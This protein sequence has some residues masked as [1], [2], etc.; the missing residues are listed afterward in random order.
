M[1]DTEQEKRKP[2]FQDYS[3]CRLIGQEFEGSL[4]QAGLAIIKDIENPDR[5]LMSKLHYS[6]YDPNKIREKLIRIEEYLRHAN[7]HTF[8]AYNADKKNPPYFPVLCRTQVKPDFTLLEVARE[9]TK[10]NSK[11]YDKQVTKSLAAKLTDSHSLNM[12]VMSLGLLVKDPNFK[13]FLLRKLADKKQKGALTGEVDYTIKRTKIESCVDD[14]LYMGGFESYTPDAMVMRATLLDD[15]EGKFLSDEYWSE[16]PSE[17]E[18]AV[19]HFSG[20]V[21]GVQTNLAYAMQYSLEQKEHDYTNNALP[22]IVILMQQLWNVGA[23]DQAMWQEIR[24]TFP[25]EVTFNLPENLKD[26]LSEVKQTAVEESY[27]EEAVHMGD[28]ESLGPKEV[29]F[30]KKYCSDPTLRPLCLSQRMWGYVAKHGAKEKLM[31]PQVTTAA[32]LR[33]TEQKD[34]RQQ[35]ARVLQSMLDNDERL[36]ELVK[37]MNLGE[38]ST[39]V[40]QIMLRLD[41]A[42]QVEHVLHIILA[43]FV[44]IHH[45]RLFLNFARKYLPIGDAKQRLETLS[46]LFDIDSNTNNE[47]V[48]LE[49]RKSLG[50]SEIVACAKELHKEKSDGKSDLGGILDRTVAI[51]QDYYIRHMKQRIAELEQALRE[52]R[53]IFETL[54]EKSKVLNSQVAALRELH[55]RMGIDLSELQVTE[56]D[57][58]EEIRSLENVLIGRSDQDDPDA[59]KSTYMEQLEAAWVNTQG[60]VEV[61]KKFAQQADEANAIMQQTL[62]ILTEQLAAYSQEAD[63][64]RARIT[65][66]LQAE[67]AAHGQQELESINEKE[68]SELMAK[69]Q[70]LEALVARIQAYLAQSPQGSECLE[71]AAKLEAAR[72]DI[73]ELNEQLAQD[74]SA[75][76]ES[77]NKR[78]KELEEQTEKLTT[79]ND[80]ARELAR[81][82]G[83]TTTEITDLVDAGVY[84]CEKVRDLTFTAEELAKARALQHVLDHL[85]RQKGA[86]AKQKKADIEALLNQLFTTYNEE[87]RDP[88]WKE[89]LAILPNQEGGLLARIVSFFIG[90]KSKRIYY[91][92]LNLPK[93]DAPQ[94]GDRQSETLQLFDSLSPDEYQAKKKQICDQKDRLSNAVQS[95]TEKHELLKTGIDQL[96][97]LVA[98]TKGQLAVISPNAEVDEAAQALVKDVSE[99]ADEIN[100]KLAN[101]KLQI[102]ASK[103]K[104]RS[105]H[106]ELS[107]V[108][109]FDF[110]SKQENLKQKHSQLMQ[111]R[112]EL[113]DEYI[114]YQ[115]ELKKLAQDYGQQLEDM[116][117]DIS[118]TGRDKK[119]GE[120]LKRLGGSMQEKAGYLSAYD[121][122]ITHKITDTVYHL[123]A[124]LTTFNARYKEHF[125]L[126]RGPEGVERTL[127]A[128][129][130]HE[131]DDAAKLSAVQE[132][133]ADKNQ[134]QMHNRVTEL[135][136]LEQIRYSQNFYREISEMLKPENQE[137]LIRDGIPMPDFK[138]DAVTLRSG[139]SPDEISAISPHS[140]APIP[141]TAEV[142]T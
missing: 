132:I 86:R 1:P 91:E 105:L 96:S 108:S 133:L 32:I 51:A 12:Q 58:S 109:E 98:N 121:D 90:T 112:Q 120:S 107:T 117:K 10:L 97:Q 94:E 69:Q 67:E 78:V 84:T 123:I 8:I 20:V 72:A 61:M 57:L 53:I 129:Y 139:L 110:P 56:L 60:P 26:W 127:E 19:A 47:I 81:D 100:G 128:L 52:S 54:Q 11:E 116:G 9:K 5:D 119:L 29:Q 49:C 21:S 115:G 64:L 30:Y 135:R 131:M 102:E 41:S 142:L 16:L 80:E 88:I 68:L 136:R 137:K 38:M 50:F 85:G 71:A 87:A 70:S 125:G 140:G 22:P 92:N 124:A 28:I 99:A 24:G 113:A 39:Y 106:N 55:Q 40:E 104:G 126:E 76:F 62:G 45:N 130:K 4:V 122:K 14:V 83:Q 13:K 114:T 43:K 111:R 134:E 42:G 27:K 103:Q 73:G 63:A 7:T 59:L 37:S 33:T 15:F 35:N 93:E 6:L 17:L 36:L 101:L 82:I 48:S 25:K 65:A 75:A 74:L 34:D 2:T 66:A 77:I 95:E 118:A 44:C 46:R 138:Q 23:L 3:A 89:I 31:V 79:L 141:S 18:P